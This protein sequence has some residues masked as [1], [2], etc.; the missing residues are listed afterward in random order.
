MQPSYVHSL[1]P[2]SYRELEYSERFKALC[3]TDASIS[4]LLHRLD[5][6]LSDAEAA[7]KLWRIYEYMK[8]HDSNDGIKSILL[9]EVSVDT[10]IRDDQWAYYPLKREFYCFALM[11]EP[12]AEFVVK[13]ISDKLWRP[14][15]LGV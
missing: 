15:M 11:D 14:H 8:M 12:A 5:Q 10:C 9:Q 2:D 13:D 3:A 7:I 6:N 1:I 4:E